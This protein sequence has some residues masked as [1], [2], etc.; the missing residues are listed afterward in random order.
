MLMY[1]EPLFRPPGEAYSLI[2]QVTLG[3]SHNSCAFCKM[4]A[5]KQFR[6]RKQEEVLEE[7]KMASRYYDGVGKIFLADGNAMVMPT[8]R[9]LAIL[10]AINTYFPKVRRVSTYALPGDILAKSPGELC[11][12]RAAGL[13]LLYV[14]MESGDPRVLEM[15]GKSETPETTEEGLLKAQQAGFSNSVMIVN[16]LAGLQYS[17]QHAVHSAQLL[18]RIQPRFLSTLVLMLPDGAE[19]YNREFKGNYVHMELLDLLKE[20]EIFLGNLELERTIF[21]SDHASNYLALKGVLSRDK[22]KLL[23]TLRSYIGRR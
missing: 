19:G 15:V 2:F 8:A 22:S 10:E 5:T 16:G 6:M 11:A 20:M 7:I 3:C 1:D 4:Y 9:L 14:G 18:N 12:L 21:R 13:E 17:E 23:Q